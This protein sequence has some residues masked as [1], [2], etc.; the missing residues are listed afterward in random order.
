MKQYTETIG[1]VEPSKIIKK[2]LFPFINNFICF[3]FLDGTRIS[4]LCFY[5]ETLHSRSLAIGEHTTL[6]ISAY[7]KLKSIQKLNQ[8]IDQNEHYLTMEGFDADA[9]IKVKLRLYLRI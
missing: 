7:V 8:F 2:V 9:A 4:Q 6:L 3:K 5:L 1:Y